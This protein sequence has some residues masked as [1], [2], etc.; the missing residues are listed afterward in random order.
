MGRASDRIEIGLD[1]LGHDLDEQREAKNQLPEGRAI[2]WPSAGEVRQL[3]GDRLA[4]VDQLVGFDVGDRRQAERSRFPIT[5]LAPAEPDGDHRSQVRIP[6]RTHEHVGA[7]PR[8]WLDD[9]AMPSLS[10]CPHAAPQ[11]L[12]ARRDRL[13]TAQSQQDGVNLAGSGGCRQVRFQRDRAGNRRGRVECLTEI[14][15]ALHRRQR[16]AMRPQ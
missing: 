2:E 6:Y 16:N 12:P 8:E 3:P 15:R 5:G 14:V 4:R 10:C 13:L 9:R 1:E 7:F 11:L